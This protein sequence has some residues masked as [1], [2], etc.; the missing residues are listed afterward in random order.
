VSHTLTQWSFDMPVDSLIALIGILMAAMW[1]P[2]PNNLMLASSGA[3]FGLRATLPHVVG[4]FLGF[5]FMFF[6]VALGLGEMFEKFPILHLALR[7]MGAGLLLWVAWRIANAKA[8]G[9]PGARTRPLTFAQAAAFQWV[10][11]KGWAMCVA[12]VGQFMH[13][14]HSIILA[15]ILAAVATFGGITS[16]TGWAVFGA[17]LQRKLRS[18]FRLK[19]FNLSMASIIVAGV[20]FA[21]WAWLGE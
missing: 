19:M 5:G 16:A 6:V 10:N 14:E 21:L 2:G 17:L 13:G 4:V 15:G 1:T 9:E 11:P 18:P 12:V 20:V 8:P 7:W 3:T